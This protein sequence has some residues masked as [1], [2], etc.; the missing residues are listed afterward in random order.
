MCFARRSN[1]QRQSLLYVLDANVRR[2]LCK[3]VL[4]LGGNAVL[5][6]RQH[7]DVEGDSG[8]VARSYGTAVLLRR[9][10]EEEEKQCNGDEEG[11]LE[12]NPKGKDDKDKI[13]AI[14]TNAN[15]I[16]STNPKV[17]EAVARIREGN[18]EED[19]HLLTLRELGE[20][21]GGRAGAKRQQKQHTAHHYN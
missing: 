18:Q 13:V 9:K 21:G 2:Q 6:Y 16:T 3:K 1:E 14:Q 5:G 10:E 17:A 20:G 4:E 7:F 19:V 15:M 8:L 12:M 11:M